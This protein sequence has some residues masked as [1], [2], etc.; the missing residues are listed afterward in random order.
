MSEQHSYHNMNFDE[1]MF[2]VAYNM[3]GDVES[4]KD[5]VQDIHLKFLENPVPEHISDRRNYVIRTTINLC[6]N[7]KR[8]TQRMQ[9]VGPWLPEPLPSTADRTDHGSMLEKKNLL[10]YELA[11]LMER[12]SPVERAVFVL[13]EAFEFDHK[14]I[15]EAINISVENS[16][17]ILKRA[18]TKVSSLKHQPVPDP[19]SLEIAQQFI[20]HISEGSLDELI[21]LF[22]KDISII[23]DGGGKAPAIRK[24]IFGQEPVAAFFMNLNRNMNFFLKYYG[25]KEGNFEYVFTKILLQP[26]IL[27]HMQGEIV[28]IL[29]LSLHRGK[30]SQI[31]SVLN[32]D[33]LSHFKKNFGNLSHN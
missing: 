13:R 33:K 27:I 25:N 24:P 7:L 23:G 4:A 26:A 17:Q 28:C 16:R 9:Y 5:I 29:I 8:K 2:S 19:V 21:A 3:T 11:F 6:L 30:I 1:L 22:N 31:F 18:K 32:P 15:A 20:T 12:L 14:E 10:S